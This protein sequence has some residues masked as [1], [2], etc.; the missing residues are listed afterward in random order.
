MKLEPELRDAL[1]GE[2]TP[3]FLAT[4]DAQGRPNCVPVISITPYEDDILIFGEFFMNKSRR[5][6]LENEKVGVAVLNDALEGWSLKGTFLGFQTVGEWVERIN[7]MFL[8]RYNAY[9][10]IRAAGGIRI[11]DASAKQRLS[12]GGLLCRFLRA[13]VAAHL[14]KRPRRNGRCMPLRVVEKF[15]R[16]NAV[17]AAAFLDTD[18]FPRAFPLMAC[19]PAGPNRLAAADPFMSTYASALNPGTDLAISIIT[20]DPIAYQVKGRYAGKWAGLH[21]IDLT[22]CYSASPPLLGERLDTPH[23]DHGHRSA[24]SV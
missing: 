5:N 20:T 2:M 6:L 23:E 7:G 21:R 8:F 19:V 1:A 24:E 15:Q 13:R 10:S 18:G 9:T 17:R 22:A 16:I 4:L 11:E 12:R 14:M 3:K